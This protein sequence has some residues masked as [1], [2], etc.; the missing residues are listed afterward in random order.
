M[1]DNKREIPLGVALI[2]VIFLVGALGT[3]IGGFGLEA[4]IP[5]ICAAAVAAGVASAYGY[6]WKEILDGMVHGINLAMGVPRANIR[7]LV[8]AQRLRTPRLVSPQKK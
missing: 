2:P 8:S 1:S 3:T 5:L 6:K 7:L 4:H